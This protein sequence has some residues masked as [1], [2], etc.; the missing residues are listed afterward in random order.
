[1]ANKHSPGCACCEV[2]DEGCEGEHTCT[3]YTNDGCFAFPGIT[4][5]VTG[6]GGFSFTGTSAMDTWGVSAIVTFTFTHSGTYTI[7]ADAP[8]SPSGRF[9][10]TP[11]RNFTLQCRDGLSGVTVPV[12][13]DY[14]QLCCC[15]TRPTWPFNFCTTSIECRNYPI[16]RTLNWAWGAYGGTATLRP[17]TDPRFP[18]L[19]VGCASVTVNGFNPDRP[20]DGHG[21]GC[22]A[23]GN[24]QPIT[25]DSEGKVWV[26]LKHCG[27]PAHDPRWWEV[28]INLPSC[29]TVDH[30]CDDGS[31]QGCQCCGP[32]GEQNNFYLASFSTNPSAFECDP[33]R[34]AWPVTGGTIMSAVS[35]AGGLLEFFE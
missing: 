19:W 33:F 6:P 31:F 27:L 24:C 1:M 25:G 3:V 17:P 21:N 14:V 7:W 2:P 18:N 23:Y 15:T 26:F 16:N 8:A 20:G 13:P 29:P 11:P 35:G 30:S 9:L 22:D 34:L 10:A 32:F 28:F 4:V 5:H 12:H